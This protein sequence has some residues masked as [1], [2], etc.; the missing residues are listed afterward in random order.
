MKLLYSLSNSSICNDLE[1]LWR[2]FPYCKLFPMWYFVF[3]AH[4]VVRLQVSVCTCRPCCLFSGKLLYPFMCLVIVK[5]FFSGQTSHLVGI[6]RGRSEVVPGQ[7][8]PLCLS[9]HLLWSTSVKSQRNMH[10]HRW[11]LCIIFDNFFVIIHIIHR[12]RKKMGPI[13]F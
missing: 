6:W 9:N 3:V 4:C 12:V 1:C 2:S 11:H 8:H 7:H 10:W 13:M 5:L